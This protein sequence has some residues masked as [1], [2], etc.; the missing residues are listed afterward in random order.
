M[1]VRAVW[2]GFNKKTLEKIQDQKFYACGIEYRYLTEK[3]H[4][5]DKHHGD[6]LARPI[7][8]E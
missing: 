6:A 4:L 7:A 2:G 1:L 8:D 3:R 5:R